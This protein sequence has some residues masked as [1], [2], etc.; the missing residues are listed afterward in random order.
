MRLLSRSLQRGGCLFTLACSL[1]KLWRRTFYSSPPPPGTAGDMRLLLGM[2]GVSK[3]VE[4]R[5][6]GSFSSGHDAKF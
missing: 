6:Q 5:S 3:V 2:A 1:S 4:E